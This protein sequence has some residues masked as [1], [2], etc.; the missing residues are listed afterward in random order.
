MITN[1]RF[2]MIII[3][4]TAIFV[5]VSSSS[6]HSSIWSTSADSFFNLWFISM[7]QKSFWTTKL[8]LNLRLKVNLLFYFDGFVLP[9]LWT[10]PIL[11]FSITISCWIVFQIVV[12]SVTLSSLT[13]AAPSFPLL[14]FLKTNSTPERERGAVEVRI[15]RVT[16]INYLKNASCCIIQ[17]VCY[18]KFWTGLS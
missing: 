10:W 15:E 8:I 4:I 11:A 6:V 18:S 2:N 1:A 5:V 12:I 7:V 13:S 16:D 3:C 14:F 9:I 17:R